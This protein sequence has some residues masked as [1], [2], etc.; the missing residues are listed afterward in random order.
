MSTVSATSNDYREDNKYYLCK[1]FR[2]LKRRPSIRSKVLVLVI[3]K[4]THSVGSP[5]SSAKEE[6]P[7]LVSAQ[8]QREWKVQRQYREGKKGSLGQNNPVTF[9]MFESNI[10]PCSLLS[11]TKGRVWTG[12]LILSTNIKMCFRLTPERKKNYIHIFSFFFAF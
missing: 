4:A 6:E 10:R 3:R 1:W 11:D 5:L 12:N 2:V 9:S 8:R 7:I